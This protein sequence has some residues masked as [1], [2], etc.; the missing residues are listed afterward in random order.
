MASGCGGNPSGYPSEFGRAVAVAGDVNGDGRADLLI[1]AP[2]A[3]EPAG[4]FCDQVG[5]VFL[6]ATLA[7][8]YGDDPGDRLG[9]AVAGELRLDADAIPDAVGGAPGDDDA[10]AECGSVFAIA[11]TGGALYRVFGDGAGDQLGTALARIGDLD[12][13]GYDEFVAGAPQ[14]ASGGSGYA[15]I[16]SGFDGTVIRTHAGAASGARTGLGL[17]SLGDLD[18]DGVPDYAVGSPGE[19][20]GGLVRVHSGA[21]GSLLRTHAAPAAGDAFGFALGGGTDLDRDGVAELVVGAPRWGAAPGSVWA[22]SGATGS[23]LLRLDGTAAIDWFGAAVAGAGDFDGDGHGDLVVG[24][25][26]ADPFSTWPLGASGPGWAAVYSGTSGETLARLGGGASPARTGVSVARRQRHRRRR[27]NDGRDCRRRDEQRRVRG[28]GLCRGHRAHRRPARRARRDGRV[29]YGNAVA[30][31]DD[32]DQDGHA[33]VLIGAPGWQGPARE[34]DPAWRA[35]SPRRAAPCCANSTAP[36][37]AIASVG[38]W[39]TRATST[40]T[41]SGICSVGSAQDHYPESAQFGVPAGYAKV[42]SARR[43]PCSTTSRDPATSPSAARWP[44]VATSMAMATTTS[45]SAARSWTW[46]K[47]DS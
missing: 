5:A 19:G 8:V 22:F 45:S 36:R 6:P 41:A 42:F 38:P 3:M 15:R 33:E 44:A 18:G 23:E 46:R 37:P 29:D 32:L 9:A 39:P 35:S 43:A 20:A 34:R 12:G 2:A 16:Y 27:A 14:A 26:Q 40:A 11:G 24:A 21:D 31:V 28:V 30:A 25:P 13:D 47:P 7:P 17:A 4:C 1:G 10:G